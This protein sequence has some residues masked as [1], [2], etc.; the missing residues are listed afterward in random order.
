M[1][2]VQHREAA[3]VTSWP[4]DREKAVFH[5]LL[6]EIGAPRQCER[7]AHHIQRTA[8]VA[9]GREFRAAGGSR[10]LVDRQAQQVAGL[11]QAVPQRLLDRRQP[12]VFLIRGAV[13]AI[14]RACVE[15]QRRAQPQVG[16]GAMDLVGTYGQV[17]LDAIHSSS[18]E[19]TE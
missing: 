8:E 18:M 15:T 9:P 6:A 1:V 14:Q 4:G 16:P 19:F 11:R 7:I 12:A 2:C 13:R 5:V 3:A 10:Y 17:Y